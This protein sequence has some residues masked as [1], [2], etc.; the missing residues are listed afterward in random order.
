MRSNTS[1]TTATNSN[2]NSD[3]KLIYT[4]INHTATGAR[5]AVQWLT[6]GVSL[7]QWVASVL[8]ST[9]L[10]T[11][12]ALPVQAAMR[13][14]AS[15]DSNQR[16]FEPSQVMRHLWQM[17]WTNLNL[18]AET[19]LTSL[20]EGNFELVAAPNNVSD[21]KDKP[22]KGKKSGAK[23]E[24]KNDA[25]NETDEKTKNSRTTAENNSAPKDE[26]GSLEKIKE[27]TETTKSKVEK[28]KIGNS[29]SKTP[30]LKKSST[31]IAPAVSQLPENERESVYTAENNLGAP[32]G[33]T[34]MD[35][36]NPA[37]TIAIRHRA[38]IANFSFGIPLAALSGRGVDAGVGS[39]RD[40]E[41][42][43]IDRSHQGAPKWL[44]IFI[45]CVPI[46]S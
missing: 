21:D 20:K 9:M 7:R 15:T 12:F 5:R 30:G 46:A 32:P 38:G 10:S 36:T 1:K 35:S 6:L 14:N 34:E 4:L 25:K 33:Q 2:I 29:G 39:L 26:S 23:N 11:I 40:V 19:W 18:Q 45:N 44:L 8:I 27:R 3:T 41:S 28:E 16:R 24:V 42:F 22:K 13:V 17:A 43:E 37:A 31:A